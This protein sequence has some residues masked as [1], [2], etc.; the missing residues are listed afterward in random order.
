MKTKY[1]FLA[2]ALVA[3]LIAGIAQAR[4]DDDHGQLR[5]GK[6]GKT[7]ELIFKTPPDGV[8]LEPGNETVIAT[9]DTSSYRRIRVAARSLAEAPGEFPAMYVY[10]AEFNVLLLGFGTASELGATAIYDVP[11]ISTTIKAFVGQISQPIAV[12]VYGER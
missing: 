12:V 11:G 8:V 10:E 4:S 1:I 5:A 6:A 2:C 9:I 7:V 3:A